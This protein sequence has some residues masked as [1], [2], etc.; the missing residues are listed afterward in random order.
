MMKNFGVVNNEHA[1]SILLMGSD[2]W[3]FTVNDCW[4]LGAVHSHL[5]FYPASSVSEANIFD[6]KHVLSITGRELYGLALFGY[7]Q[8]IGHP[9]I[10][11]VFE[12]QNPG[13]ATGA[14]LKAYQQAM[15]NLSKAGA[16]KTFEN[17]GFQIARIGF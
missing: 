8:E 16:Q 5:P 4:L 17:A 9:S 13:K 11:S 2:N 10:G 3:N 14:T 15:N 1:G 12:I 6:D 7:R